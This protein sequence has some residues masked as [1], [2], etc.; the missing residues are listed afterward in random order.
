LIG[1][2]SSDTFHELL[3]GHIKAFQWPDPRVQ[4]IGSEATNEVGRILQSIDHMLGR[5]KLEV[6]GS[7][8]FIDIELP[9]N[10]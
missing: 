4:V 2:I 6:I 7:D 9:S 10:K 1:V 8:A 5:S 3:R